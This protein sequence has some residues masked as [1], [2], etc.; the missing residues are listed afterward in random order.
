[1]KYN[2]F[3]GPFD[4]LLFISWVQIIPIMTKPHRDTDER[5]IIK[6]L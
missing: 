6:L 3:I 5:Y 4:D 2:A 1:M